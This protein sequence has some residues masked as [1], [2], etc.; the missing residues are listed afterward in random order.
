M[1]VVVTAVLIAPATVGYLSLLEGW[2]PRT[3]TTVGALV[4]VWLVVAVGRL[5]RD[6]VAVGLV[7]GTVTG[8]LLGLAYHT[9]AV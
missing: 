8:A 3:A 5:S 1:T 7:T 9:H 2:E 6:E 4:A